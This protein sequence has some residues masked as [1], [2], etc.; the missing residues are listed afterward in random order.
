MNNL[1]IKV[2]KGHLTTKEKQ[3][4]KEMINQKLDSGRVGRTDYFIRT[5][6][7]KNYNSIT[8]KKERSCIGSPLKERQYHQDFILL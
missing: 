4:I 6:D 8:V 7:G 2:I 1:R 5:V 3:V